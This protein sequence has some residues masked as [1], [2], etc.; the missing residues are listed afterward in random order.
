M[1]Y[2]PRRDAR[3]HYLS[4]VID[5][6][7]SNQCETCR[8]Q[9]EPGEGLGFMCYEIEGK[10]LLENPVHGLDDEGDAGVVCTE[11]KPEVYGPEEVWPDGTYQE[12][13][14]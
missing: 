11:Y 1:T 8:F 14:F 2:K 12:R 9:K 13:L 6:I 7:E 5:H 10:I 4:D 3:F